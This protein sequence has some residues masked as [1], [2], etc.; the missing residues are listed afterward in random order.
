MNF[1]QFTVPVNNGKKLPISFRLDGHNSDIFIFHPR[2]E[3]KF[4][5]PHWLFDYYVPRFIANEINI[6][7]PVLV[8]AFIS[9]EDE[10]VAVPV[11]VIE[12]KERSD[13]T[14]LA[15]I[16]KTSYKVMIES[17]DKQKQTLEFGL[18]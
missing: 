9:T 7:F 10:N 16:P 6:P 12:I 4:N 1:K 13:S 11:D 5:R 14:A 18:K 17:K 3:L 2:T 15:L 8:K